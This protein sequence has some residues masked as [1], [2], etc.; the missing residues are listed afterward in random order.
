M[1]S[2]CVILLLVSCTN[3]IAKSIV[4]GRSLTLLL[5]PISKRCPKK[6]ARCLLHS[7]R[8][9][10]PQVNLYVKLSSG[11]LFAPVILGGLE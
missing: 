8:R 3:W 11:K 2:Y 4:N 9:A 1:C 5:Y 10:D 6:T 7:S